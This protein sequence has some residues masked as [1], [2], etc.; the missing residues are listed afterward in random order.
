MSDREFDLLLF[1]TIYSYV[2]V[3]S[4]AKKVVMIHDVIAEKYPDL[5]VPRSTARFF[6]NTKVALG[7]WQADAIATVSDYSRGS[8]LEHF[9]LAAERVFVVGEANDP[10]FCV[11]EDP[12]PSPRLGSLG[13]AGNGRSVVYVG[14]FSPHKNLE[15]LVETFAKLSSRPDFADV[16]LV[17]VGEYEK[18]VFYS[19]FGTIKK[20]VETAGLKDRVIFT[21]YLPDDELVIL[22]NLATVL[23]LP[24]LLE[25]FGLPAIEAAACGCPVV[26]T[27]ASPLPSLLGDGALY[28]DPT[29]QRELEFVLER[30]L[31]SAELRQQ[32]RAAGLAAAG[33]LTWDAAARQMI[34]V[35]QKVMTQ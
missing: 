35:M 27:K 14:G 31:T 21:G 30:V 6:W 28:I 9:G 4:R 15:M 12:Q 3:F 17:M 20:Q 7:R 25:G 19:Y 34:N 18:E 24:S 10:T 26:A 2:P 13:F 33:R 11:M 29:D 22:L 1:P 8:I 5:T 16:R 32:I 23:V